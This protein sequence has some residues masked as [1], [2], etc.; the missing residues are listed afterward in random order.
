[1]PELK[2]IR[3]KQDYAEALARVDV[4]MG[5]LPDSAEGREL[6]LLV[7]LVVA[8]EDKHV[9]MEYPNPVEVIKF[10]MEQRGL[11]PR[12]LVPFIGSRAKVS[13]VLSGKRKITMPMARALH[14][15]LDIPAESL[16]GRKRTTRQFA[17]SGRM[18]AVSARHD[19]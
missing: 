2:P 7:D 14:E 19:G 10:C 18:D 8:Y 11:E 1:M 9:P 13:E 6:D 16:P 12:D 5:A 17:V 15:N 4:L 3:T